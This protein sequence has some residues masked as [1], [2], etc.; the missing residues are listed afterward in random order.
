MKKKKKQYIISL[1]PPKGLICDKKYLR[2]CAKELKK[3][4][5]NKKTFIVFPIPV[6][7]A[8]IQV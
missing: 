7:V 6:R 8:E 3:F 4:L 2:S 1:E 5:K